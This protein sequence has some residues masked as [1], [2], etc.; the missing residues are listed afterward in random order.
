[1][2]AIFF[3]RESMARPKKTADERRSERFNIRYTIAERETAR[4]LA[5]RYG[6]DEMEFHRR[7]VL[8][9]PLPASGI[10]T[11]DP[12]LVAALNAHAVALSKI[13]NN[14]NQLAAATH[15][16]RDFVRYWRE[17]GAEL[18]ADLTASREALN[19][20]LEAMDG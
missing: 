3:E 9:A 20:V 15:Q 13:G 17:I 16:G 7:R 1:M 19:R 4:D 14:V 8:G 11:V 10:A 12:V 18:Q 5:R 6:L 2:D